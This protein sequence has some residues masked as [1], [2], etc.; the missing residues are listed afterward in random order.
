M[1]IKKG[2]I[3]AVSTAFVTLLAA[4]LSAQDGTRTVS[5][6]ERGECIFSTEVMPKN[7][8][9]HSAYKKV[10]TVF[11]ASDPIAVR[12]FYEDGNQSN[13][14][15]LGSVANSM[16]D[17]GKYYAEFEWTNENSRSSFSDFRI[18]AVNHNYN[19]SWDQQRYDLTSDYA[20]CDFKLRG[21]DKSKYRAKSDGCMD[22]AGF[23]KSRNISNPGQQEF[24]VRIFMKFANSKQWRTI[25][26]EQRLE[27][28]Y[29]E[30][31]MSRGCFKVDLGGARLSLNN[32]T[33]GVP[34][35]SVPADNGVVLANLDKACK[36]MPYGRGNV[37]QCV[38]K[39]AQA[40][41]LNYM[42]QGAANLWIMSS[43]NPSAFS[44]SERRAVY[45][46]ASADDRAAAADP[47]MAQLGGHFLATCV[48]AQTMRRS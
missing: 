37:C 48:N 13:Y 47:A 21:R 18:K 26:N 9:S 2:M 40:K 12:C 24:C 32:A 14:R 17:S 3:S 38:R 15:S 8:F 31:T 39:E 29:V 11:S 25:G 30:K 22:F 5:G 20:E 6:P 42:S 7:Q 34:T 4:P 41:G 45:D 16:R 33:V 28:V 43:F 1:L 19:G 35:S 46:T 36:Q 23:I 27:P 10:K 44:E